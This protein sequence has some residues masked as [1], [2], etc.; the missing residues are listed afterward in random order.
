MIPVQAYIEVA[1]ALPV[2]QTFTYG[3]PDNLSAFI[4]SG[5]RVLVPF[6]QRRVTGYILGS[7]DKLADTEI[8]VVLDVL[9]EHP[10]FP[11]SMIPFFKWIAEYYKYPLGDVIKT[12]LP[13]GLNIYDYISIALTDKGRQALSEGSLTPLESKI[14]AHL[15]SG[16][17]R[18]R[19]LGKFIN[20]AVP[21]ALIQSLIRRGR[22]TKIRQLSGGTTKTRTQRY[23]T[24]TGTDIRLSH[25]AVAQQKII[26]FLNLEGEVSVKALKKRVP[27]AATLIRSM[28][29]KGYVSI[30]HKP[31]YRDPFGETILPETAPVLTAEQQPVVDRL[32]GL[33]NAGFH[34]LLLRGVTGSGKTEV[35]MQVAAEA[36]NKALSVLVLVPEIALITQMERRFRARFGDR[37]AVLHSGLSA[38]ERYDQWRRI[39]DKQAAITIGARSAIFAPLEDIGIIIVDEEHDTSYKQESSLRYNARDLAVMRAK[40]NSAVALLGSATP[41]LQ[42]YYNVYR[43]KFS[44]VN[45][46]ERIEKRPLPEISVIDLRQSR[47]ARGIRRFITPELQREMTITL[48]R[49]E[50]VLLFLNRR[51]F[52][53]F[54]I[55][56][57]CGQALRCKHCDISLTLHQNANAYRCH[58]CGYSRA[59][60]S[61]CTICGSARVKHLGLGTE[62]VEAAVGDLFPQAR[63]A[64][65]DRDTTTRKGSILALL[66]GVNDK[67]I[68][69]LVGT[70]MVAKGHDFPN[71]TL[72]GIIC[73]DLSLSFPDFRAGERTFQLLAQVAGR[74]GR[75]EVPGR[76]ILQTYNPE[77]F[78][79]LAAREQDFLSF[80]AQE[81][82]FR[83]ALNYPPISRMI[84][85]K[86]SGK[87][88]SKTK[89]HARRLG[90]MCQDLKAA[91]PDSFNAVALMGPIE[92]SLP[93]IA[94][95]YRWQ[96]LLKSENTR[97]LHEFMGT[98]L[99]EHPTHFTHRSVKTVI[100]VDPYFIM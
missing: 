42:S 94:E 25:R 26:D 87:D 52:A 92:A 24:L 66:K 93:R 59:S 78:S 51:G 80:Y 50:Q 29:K 77:H 89:A 81:I 15:T 68:D 7:T 32:C 1:V 27:S 55:C 97:A 14:L 41:S 13:G 90:D 72:V 3:V 35:Y 88:Q 71:I 69:V 33:L 98:L 6:G 86:I 58:Y 9:D 12:A 67:T 18:L 64:R 84:Q 46:N 65:M 47:D 17:C 70:Q 83:K 5:K 2:F 91:D 36:M 99:T 38:G 19:D 63:I 30:Q 39:L 53:S 16:S 40:L 4:A 11:E 43:R 75:G 74:A 28:E 45:L 10:L 31:E 23:V 100:D 34:S 60:S 73:A 85:L 96:L 76:V 54:P 20:Q 56:A 62:K 37:V 22:I 48:E 82:E 57:S 49:G 21:A 8:K 61:S 44:E 95:H 79:I